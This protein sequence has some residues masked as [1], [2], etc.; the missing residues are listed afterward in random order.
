MS[1]AVHLAI[2]DGRERMGSITQRRDSKWKASDANGRK[3]GGTFK[4]RK[5]AIE[6]ITT[7]YLVSQARTGQ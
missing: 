5:Q 3:L 2:Y 4:T 7:K 6:A 1:A